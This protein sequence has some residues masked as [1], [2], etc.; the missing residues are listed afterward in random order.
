MTLFQLNCATLPPSFALIKHTDAVLLK[1]DACWLLN[2]PTAW[3]TSSLY[4]LEHDVKALQIPVP[5]HFVAISD[6][7]WVD[8]TLNYQQVVNCR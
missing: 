4:V 8:L 6:S 5:T 7:Q 1:R 2:H 3:P